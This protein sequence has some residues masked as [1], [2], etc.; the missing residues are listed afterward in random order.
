MDESRV[1]GA[2]DDWEYELEELD[3]EAPPDEVVEAG[4]P[5]L[6]GAAFVVLG[7]VATVVAL[8]RMLPGM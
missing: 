5:T 6:E 2:A 4:T 3:D 7:A 8:L 1:D